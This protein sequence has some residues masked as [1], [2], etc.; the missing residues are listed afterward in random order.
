VL[1]AAEHGSGATAHGSAIATGSGAA[2]L[3]VTVESAPAPPPTA[4][5]SAEPTPA[6][7]PT[8]PPVTHPPPAGEQMDV[9]VS[10]SGV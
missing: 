5:Q 7:A 10:G 8:E 1:G 9:S 2:D 6:P 3:E 4:P